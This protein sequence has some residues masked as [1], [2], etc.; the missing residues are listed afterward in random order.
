MHPQYTRLVI[1]KMNVTLNVI[2][3]VTFF[4]ELLNG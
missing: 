4:G 2:L 1:A 3:N